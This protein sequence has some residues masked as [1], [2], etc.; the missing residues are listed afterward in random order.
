MAEAKKMAI[1][2]LKFSVTGDVRQLLHLQRHLTAARDEN[3]DT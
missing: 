2:M 1:A 3:G